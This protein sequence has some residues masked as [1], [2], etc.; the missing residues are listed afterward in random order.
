MVSRLLK[1]WIPTDYGSR[2]DGLFA[3]DVVKN[4]VE[5]VRAG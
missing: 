3:S 1:C 5:Y 4:E 2:P